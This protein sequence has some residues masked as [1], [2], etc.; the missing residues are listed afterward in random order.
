V[1]VLAVRADDMICLG[2]PRPGQLAAV[3]GML[4]GLSWRTNP[5]VANIVPAS[6]PG[7]PVTSLDRAAVPCRGA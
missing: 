6:L 5:V 7:S 3:V 4:T 1:T 2:I